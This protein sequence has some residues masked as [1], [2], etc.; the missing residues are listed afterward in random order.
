MVLP[1]ALAS[2]VGVVR[3]LCCLVNAASS[4]VG[5]RPR[6]GG[7]VAP[8]V[9]PIAS[10]TVY[11]Y[12]QIDA[13]KVRSWNVLIYETWCMVKTFALQTPRKTN[14][15]GALRYA[16]MQIIGRARAARAKRI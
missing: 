16:P 11:I 2:V 9:A 15:R 5:K 4:G 14:F 10:T 8:G 3:R 7:V 1:K 12:C 6:G 13:R